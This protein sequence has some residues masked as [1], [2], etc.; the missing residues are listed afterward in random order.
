MMNGLLNSIDSKYSDHVNQILNSLMK[1]VSSFDQGT[2]DNVITAIISTGK[3]LFNISTNFNCNDFLSSVIDHLP[4]KSDLSEDSSIVK[5]LLFFGSFS[6]S[7]SPTCI[8]KISKVLIKMLA[9]GRPQLE[10]WK[11]DDFELLKQ[12]CILFLSEV[13]KKL[14]NQS[15][16]ILSESLYQHEQEFL[17]QAKLVF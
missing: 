10:R 15:K 12:N 1:S 4:L 6:E 5:N 3:I 2:S 17:Q 16:K 11:F 7:L 13:S 8:I 14:D 9:I